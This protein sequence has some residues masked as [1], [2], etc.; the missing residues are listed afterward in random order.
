[1][2]RI[3]VEAPRW[4]LLATLA[5]APWAY[6]STRP[7]AIRILSILLGLTCV[8]WIVECLARRRWPQVPAPPAIAAGVLLLQG[9][10]MAINSHSFFDTQLMTLFPTEPLV[11]GLPGSADGPLSLVAML[12][13]TG[14]LGVLLFCC[15]LAQRPVWR[16]R[17]WITMALVSFTIALYGILQKIGGEPVMALLWEPT[18]R[19]PANNFAAFRYRGNAGAFLNIALPL[20]AG[21]AFVAFQKRAQQGGKTFW[22]TALLV[23]AVGIQLN[24]SRVSWAIALLL[25]LA[26]GFKVFRFYRRERAEEFSP[27]AFLTYGCIM[28]LLIGSIIGISLMGRWETSWQRISLLG[29]N[30]S[31]RSPTEIFFSMVPDAGVFGFGPGTFEVVFPGYQGSYDFGRR[32]VPE[33]W[34][35]H[36][37]PHAHQDYLQTFIEWGYLGAALWALLIFGGLA[38]GLVHYAQHPKDLSWRWLL[39]CSLLAIGG[40]LIHALI[41]FPLQIAAIQFYFCVLLGI[42]WSGKSSE[43]SKEISRS[44]LPA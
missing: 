26:L 22:L 25:G 40:T 24:P 43:D 13:F 5:F 37:W 21:L 17:I 8:L 3:L 10:W 2:I 27:S 34:T 15:D 32:K 1:M 31:D 36:F 18:K 29:L 30:L 35:T 44:A 20:V 9:W 16:K 11:H 38:R 39:L 6:G 14:L 7:W 23:I 42:C 41:D 33:F 4:L 12:L 19:D 28:I